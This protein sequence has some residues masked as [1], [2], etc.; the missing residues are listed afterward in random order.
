MSTKAVDPLGHIRIAVSDFTRSQIF[1][2]HLFEQLNF[3]QV[4][5]KG[6]VSPEG[7]GIWILQAAHLTPSYVFE[8]PG[9]HHVCFKADSCEAVDR[10]HE[11]LLK[12]DVRIITAPQAYPQYTDEYYAVFFTDPDGIELEVAYY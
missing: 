8:S 2:G 10:L 1:Y 3:R 4:S 6:W 9:L 11:F 12:S 7:L 5:P